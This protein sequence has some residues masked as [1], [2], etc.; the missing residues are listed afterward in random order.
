MLAL[1]YLLLQLVSVK[2]S[3]SFRASVKPML[4]DAQYCKLSAWYPLSRHIKG[5][6]E[7]AVVGRQLSLAPYVIKRIPSS[8]Y[9]HISK[10]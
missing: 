9:V 4:A 1:L 10:I 6:N 2:T 3:V 5:A 8:Y 7:E